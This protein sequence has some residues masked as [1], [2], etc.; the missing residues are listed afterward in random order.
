MPSL[1]LTVF[2]GIFALYTAKLLI[3]FKINHP[4]VHN[5][6]NSL[7]SSGLRRSLLTMSVSGDAGFILFG[8]VG[9]EVLSAGTVIFAI[10]GTVSCMST[11]SQ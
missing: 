3:D 1:V 7:S 10:F 5:M 11:R 9:R 8:P 2:L 4:E 6:G